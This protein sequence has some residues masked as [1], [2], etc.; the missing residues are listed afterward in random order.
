MM[1]RQDAYHTPTLQELRKMLDLSPYALARAAGVRPRVAYWM[2]VGV[3]VSKDDAMKKLGV[4]SRLTGN[5][6]TIFNV[7]GLKIRESPLLP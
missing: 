2:E 6:Y 4:I 3:T 7:R 5:N 1:D